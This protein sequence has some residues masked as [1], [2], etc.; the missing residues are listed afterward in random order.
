MKPTGVYT[1]LL[2]PFKHDHLDEDALRERIDEQRLAGVDGLVVAATTG[3]GPSLE[4]AEWKRLIEI[5][6]EE[7]NGLKIIANSGTNNT[8]HSIA[9]TIMAKELGADAALVITPYYNKP[10]QEGLFKHF[11]AVASA[12]DFPIVLY[13]VPSRTGCELLPETC[14]KL[15]SYPNIVSLKQAVPNLDRVTEIKQL[16]KEQWTIL[17]GED[18]LFLPMLSIGAEGIISA[19]ANVIPDQMVA[20]WK[21]FQENDLE[22]AKEIHYHIYDLIK[23]LFIE[24][25]PAPLKTAMKMRDRSC[26]DVRLPLAPLSEKW[27]VP[28]KRALEK[29]LEVK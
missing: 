12:T 15:L 26:G 19:T 1:A 7:A 9:K 2:T 17:S 22:R 14:E 20:L 25:S 11:A 5:C 3:E 10:S 13:N 24:T 16:V 21:A 4:P 27:H 18:S 23:M 28:L 6:V 8:Q 29:A